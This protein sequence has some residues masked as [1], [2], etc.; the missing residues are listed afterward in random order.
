MEKKIIIIYVDTRN[1]ENEFGTLIVEN[2][3]IKKVKKQ[4]LSQFDKDIRKFINVIV[5]GSDSNRIEEFTNIYNP[6]NEIIEE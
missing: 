1:K 2:Q 5:M 3:I 6:I 4:F